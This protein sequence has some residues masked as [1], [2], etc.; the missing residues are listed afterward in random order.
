MLV[1]SRKL[2]EGIVI[3][4]DIRITVVKVERN[5]VRLGIEAPGDVV[6]VREELLHDT[7]H[8]EARKAWE[9]SEPESGR[10]AKAKAK[11]SG[12]PDEA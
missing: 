8:R 4:T 11:P 12:R 2:L 6:V 1:L 5:H 10:E 7:E 9:A 3:G